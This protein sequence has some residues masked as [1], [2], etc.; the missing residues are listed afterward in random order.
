MKDFEEQGAELAPSPSL[1]LSLD[2]R[3][4]ASLLSIAEGVG[5]DVRVQEDAE[6]FYL[7]LL[8]HLDCSRPVVEVRLVQSLRCPAANLSRDRDQR[9]LDLSLHLP[10]PAEGEGE[11]GGSS[12]DSALRLHFAPETLSG[13]NRYRT[14]HH[15]LQDAEKGLSLSR[16]CPLP[17]VLAVHLKRFSF[18][19][20]SGASRKLKTSVGI[21]LSI[22][23]GDANTNTPPAL[24][25][26]EEERYTLTSVV[27]HE[28]DRLD[29]GHYF[30][31]VPHPPTSKLNQLTWTELNDWQVSLADSAWASAKVNSSAYMLFYSKTSQSND[32]LPL[33]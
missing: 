18:D 12:L 17:P 21:P 20:E 2:D 14:P 26:R 4:L 13:D 31:L 24:P 1:S 19:P 16:D 11:G 29:R 6:E 15:G 5:V 9:F 8:S 7:R 33:I 23:L 27:V 25:Q 32:S 22:A 10:P 28:G 3:A 30:C